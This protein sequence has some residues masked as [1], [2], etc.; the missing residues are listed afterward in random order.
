MALCTTKP[1]VYPL[2]LI[3]ASDVV[4]I[5]LYPQTPPTSLKPRPSINSVVYL[6]LFETIPL[7]HKHATLVSGD[8]GDVC[9]LI[10]LVVSDFLLSPYCSCLGRNHS[11]TSAARIRPASK[12]RSPV[13]VIFVMCAVRARDWLEIW[14]SM[15]PPA[16][17]GQSTT[18]NRVE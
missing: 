15:C 8:I 10:P 5:R 7:F 3:G 12:P 13:V 18:A 1:N 6:L 14:L 17:W 11:V 16:W 9:H 4:P 2:P